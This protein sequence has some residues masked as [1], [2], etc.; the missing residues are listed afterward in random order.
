MKP[1]IDLSGEKW[2]DGLSLSATLPIGGRFSVANAFNPFE[3]PGLMQPSLAAT[4][5]G[6]VTVTTDIKVLV[7]YTDGTDPYLI[8]LSNRNASNVG[9]YKINAAT[10][11]VTDVSNLFFVNYINAQTSVTGAAILY[12]QRILYSTD[13]NLRSN[14]L[15]DLN[16]D[17]NIG[18]TTTNPVKDFVVAPDG[19]VYYVN[20]TRQLGYIENEL[21][22][23]GNVQTGIYD[24]GLGVYG[25][26]VTTDGNYLVMASDINA[27][28]ISGMPVD[29]TIDFWDMDTTRPSPSVQWKIPDDYII[30]T[31]FMD[32][33]VYV[34]GYRHIWTCSVSSAPKIFYTYSTNT[35]NRRPSSPSHIVVDQGAIYWGDSATSG[36]YISAYG[37]PIGTKKIF[38]S[39]YKVHASTYSQTALAASGNT[40]FAATSSNKLFQLNTGSTRETATVTTVVEPTGSH[41]YLTTKVVL[42]RPLASG[43]SVSVAAY[44]GSGTVVS[45]TQTISYNAANP[46]RCLLFP[47]KAATGSSPKFEELYVSAS[48]NAPIER[49]STY[50]TPMEELIQY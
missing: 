46:L 15:S 21:G 31:R 41:Q 3:K 12:K 33:V 32:G 36:Q 49:V 30:A 34:F 22:T 11:A 8:G 24:F 45:D 50:A 48:S 4:D 43:E 6:G 19:H 26:S 47:I 5:R 17:V 28:N 7:P 29:C 20:A 44:S 23:S 13:T 9:A 42:Q 25:K 38:F 39:P 37:S 18:S 10:G 35:L 40:M 16:A 27:N 14:R 1:I 2:L